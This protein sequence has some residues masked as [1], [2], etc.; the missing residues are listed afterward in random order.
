MPRPKHLVTLAA[1]EREQLTS[2]RWLN[3]SR[4]Q[5]GQISVDR[6][7]QMST[8]ALTRACVLQMAAA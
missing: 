3:L 6:D 4:H 7:E 1:E 5:F 2:L 8:K